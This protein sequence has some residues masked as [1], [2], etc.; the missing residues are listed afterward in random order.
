MAIL[1]R[2]LNPILMILLGLAAGGIVARQRDV[3]WK[4]YGMGAITFIGSQGLHIPFNIWILT[5]LLAMVSATLPGEAARVAGALALGLSAGVFEETARYLAY[6]FWAKDARWKDA[7]MLGAGHGGIEAILLGFLALATIL[8]LVS[9]TGKDLSN[10]VPSEQLPLARQQI[11]AFWSVPWYGVLLGAIERVIAIC[12][13]LSASV[14]VL[15]TFRRQ[16]IL[17]LL[18]AIAWHALLNAL[19]VYASQTVS[20]YATEGILAG[21]SLLCFW[22]IFK[23]RKSD[24]TPETSGPIPPLLLELKEKDVPHPITPD[25]LE[26]SKY[27]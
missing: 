17:W 26:D 25:H 14:I 19:A 24:E 8:N 3:E 16:N 1:I 11:E 5:P 23:L 9:F 27:V 13:H 18:G 7:L 2:I 20:A 15:Q 6:R 4:F 12:F 21:F 22:I 10:F